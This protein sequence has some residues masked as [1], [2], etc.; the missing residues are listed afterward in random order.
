VNRRTQLLSPLVTSSAEIDAVTIDA[1]GTL[2]EL[3]DPV[4]SLARLLPGHDRDAIERAFLAEAEHYLVHSLH[5]RDPDSLAR[6]YAEC[7]GVFNETLGSSLA[8]EEYVAALDAEYGVLPG[9][10]DALA[11][12]RALGLELAVVGNWDCRLPEHLE[13]L[14]LAG[15]FTAIV[16]SAATGA[17]K[18]DPRPFL[19]ALKQLGVVPERAL[20]I[21]DSASDE[22]GARAAGM[23]FAPVPLSTLV[24]QL[25]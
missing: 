10:E 1:Y 24:E 15:H 9:V 22:E 13:R 23:H 18:P 6:L 17:A 25:G 4:A 2:L 11:R 8:P 16:T 5:G 7:A 12:L 21:G 14:G 20:H 19:A 3:R